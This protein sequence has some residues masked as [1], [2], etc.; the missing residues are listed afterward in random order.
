MAL[1]TS[2]GSARAS[3][4]KV[5]KRPA[6]KPSRLA[7][8]ALQREKAPKALIRKYESEPRPLG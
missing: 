8:R 7:R 5:P 6:Y 1:N 4:R 3:L 2:I